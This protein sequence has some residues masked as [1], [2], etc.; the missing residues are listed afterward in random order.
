MKNASVFKEKY[1][2]NLFQNN[3]QLIFKMV[4]SAISDKL[5]QK[6]MINSEHSLGGGCIN[7]AS[8][9]KTSTGNFFLK[10]ND[11]CAADIFIREAE[12]LEELKKAAGD[13]LIVPEV[14]AA[15]TV[16]NTPGFLVLEYIESSRSA[17]ASEEKLGKGLATIHNFSNPQFGFYANNYCG[18]TLQNNNWNKSWPDF[19]RDNRLR[20]LLNLI[21]KERPLV[22]N[23]RKIFEKLLERIENLL[24]AESFPALI[25]GDLWSGNYMISEKGPALIDPA[26]YYADRE[27]ELS[28]MTM[29]GGF[30]Q[31]FYDAYNEFNPLPT[32][33]KQRNSL[34]QLYH[35]LNHYYLFGGGYLNQA[36]QV[37]KRYL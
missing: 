19:F 1:T 20:F 28:I 7:H 8:K 26:S 17:A 24:P 5:G 29:F 18:A 6:V 13:F 21:H 2:M 33:W 31:R 32:D 9:L 10:W 36:L 15:K 23:D 34:Y 12:S 35:V 16:D 37:A 4:A 3:N 27:M 14:I 22:S 25:H 30:S 11:N